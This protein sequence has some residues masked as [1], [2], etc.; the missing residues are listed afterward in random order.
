MVERCQHI[1]YMLSCIFRTQIQ[2]RDRTQ[3]SVELAF[4]FNWSYCGDAYTATIICHV[5]RNI[6]HLVFL[7]CYLSRKGNNPSSLRR[8]FLWRNICSAISSGRSNFNL[9]PVSQEIWLLGRKR[10]QRRLLPPQLHPFCQFILPLGPP[11][12]LE[13]PRLFRGG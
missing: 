2:F 5:T 7:F 9:R 3:F 4:I 6:L 1:F 13:S 10:K 8:P 11:Y 12:F